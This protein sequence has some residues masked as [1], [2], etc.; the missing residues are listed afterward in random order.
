MGKNLDVQSKLREEVRSILKDSDHPDA[1]LI[2]KMP[3]L[4]ACVKETLRS[5]LKIIVIINVFSM[6][7][8]KRYYINLINLTLT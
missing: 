6:Y 2:E 7:K 4:R 3:Y 5:V 1:S 8:L